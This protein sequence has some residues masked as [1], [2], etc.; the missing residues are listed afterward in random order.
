M[1][2]ILKFFKENFVFGVGV[3]QAIVIL[4]FLFIND[5]E[6]F[7][8]ALKVARYFG[9]IIFIIWLNDKRYKFLYYLGYVAVSI[10][11]G[12]ILEVVLPNLIDVIVSSRTSLIILLSILCILESIVL[13][14]IYNIF[15]DMSYK[16]NSD[17]IEL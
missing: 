9:V 1:K 10:F 12:K 4:S 17:N 2:K 7:K 5:N 14:F 16:K 3:L 8:L 6:L 15:K 13:Q 11:L